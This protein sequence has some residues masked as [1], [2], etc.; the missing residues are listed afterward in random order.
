MKK[1]YILA[2]LILLLPLL[3]GGYLLY[4]RSAGKNLFPTKEERLAELRKLEKR[5]E[6]NR[7]DTASER[8]RC[9]S[10]LGRYYK[11]LRKMYE[12]THSPEE[13]WFF[14][15]ERKDLFLKEEKAEDAYR[16]CLQYRKILD[17]YPVK[18]NVNVKLF[19]L[20]L[21]LGHIQILRGEKENAEKI[22][23]SCSKR[24]AVLFSEEEKSGYI[25]RERVKYFKYHLNDL[26]IKMRLIGYRDKKDWDGFYKVLSEQREKYSSW[27]NADEILKYDGFLYHLI[28]MYYEKKKEFSLADKY[29]LMCLEK[30]WKRKT[31]FL[32]NYEMLVRKYWKEKNYPAALN[33]CKKVLFP[34]REYYIFE[35]AEQGLRFAGFHLLA[36]E[37]CQKLGKEKEASGHRTAALRLAEKEGL[38]IEMLKSK[39]KKIFNGS[40]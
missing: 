39:S 25:S 36:A 38:N 12:L 24:I 32:N 15:S 17:E 37:C 27:E 22:F 3:L 19:L 6:N 9:H 16:F 5:I 31:I 30:S 2:F 18:K 4:C 40:E 20:D 14:Y 7:M 33:L 34:P 29:A 1:E 26:I 13:Y 23:L 8:K 11:L 28:A 21:D 35:A 10:D